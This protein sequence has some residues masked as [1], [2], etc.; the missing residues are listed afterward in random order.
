M[1]FST[2]NLVLSSLLAAR[3]VLAQTTTDCD[4]TKKSCPAD[5]ALGTSY[6]SHD[7]TK[8]ADDDNWK[9]TAGSI[10]YTDAGA[11]FTVNKRG[12][13]PTIQS[14]WYMFF[15]SVSFIMRSAPGQ[16]IVS[17]AILQSDD[18]DEI[19]WEWLGGTV[20]NVQS[21]Y[22]S[23]GD[24]STY[25]RQ[26][27][28][29]IPSGDAQATSHNYTIHWAK[30]KTEWII[31]GGVVR[32]LNYAEVNDAYGY[33]QTP[34]NVRIGI[35]AGGDPGNAEGT[36]EWAGGETDYSNGPYSMIVEKV[37]VVNYAPADE[38]EY[39]DRS[40]TYQSIEVVKDG[41]SSKSSSKSPSKSASASKSATASSSSEESTSASVS[42]SSA[43]PSPTP[44][45]TT[46]DKADA[47]GSPTMTTSGR[48]LTGTAEAG[49]AK[50][51][52][53][54]AAI[55]SL[56]WKGL[57]VLTACALFFGA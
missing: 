52:S 3:T 8:G 11:E 35:W 45:Q 17:S 15:G 53:G 30:D 47:S 13:A 4:P 29:A 48:W 5:P 26:G 42:A 43:S 49:E 23:K 7:F 37:E 22:F 38:Y 40:G 19:D 55:S 20:D 36:I 33:P 18:L 54:A 28:A 25:N 21:N 41:D 12:D 32:T 14:K 57:A 56:G 27:N 50:A 46:I 24:A 39:G 44:D 9:V 6:Y 10:K 51:E 31:D 1:L 16:G 34:M 2:T